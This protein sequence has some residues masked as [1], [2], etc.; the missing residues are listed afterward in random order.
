MTFKDFLLKIKNAITA[1]LAAECMKEEPEGVP[2]V[3]EDL[4]YK[5]D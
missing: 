4:E 5:W 1:C 3:P 2:E